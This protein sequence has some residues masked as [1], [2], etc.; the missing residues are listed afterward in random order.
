MLLLFIIV[1]TE[2]F[3][4]GLICN[5]TDEWVIMSEDHE[6]RFICY[7]KLLGSYVS[8]LTL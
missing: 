8:T 7:V 5:I 3:K 6:D 1:S 2:V 4:R